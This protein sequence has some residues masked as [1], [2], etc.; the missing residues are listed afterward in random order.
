MGPY[1]DAGPLS[2]APEV[3]PHLC[4]VVLTWN[5]EVIKSQHRI[6]ELTQGNRKLPKQTQ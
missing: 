2:V 1:G 4:T 6:P 3:G 5:C